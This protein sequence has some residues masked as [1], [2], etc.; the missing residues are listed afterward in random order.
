M[1][2]KTF[3][4]SEVTTDI[5]KVGLFRV[6]PSFESDAAWQA[7]SKSKIMTPT[8]KSEI[9]LGKHSN[10]I[11][12]IAKGKA[13]NSLNDTEDLSIAEDEWSYKADG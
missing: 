9:D 6:I 7:K 13:E 1:L 5:F 8:D 3:W 11:K 4:S 2:T 12:D 10:L